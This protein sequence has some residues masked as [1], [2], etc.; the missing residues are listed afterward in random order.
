MAK[1]IIS[2][3]HAWATR[4]EY[5]CPS[6]ETTPSSATDLRRWSI[7]QTTTFRWALDEDA[8]QYQLAGFKSI[9]V[10]RKKLEEFGVERGIDLIQES[11]LNVSSLSWAGG[12]TGANG[13]GFDE[14]IDDAREAIQIASDINADALVVSPGTRAGHTRKHA[15]RLLFDALDVLVDDAAKADVVLALQPMHRH[16]SAQWTYL[17]SIDE[18]LSIL[19]YYSSPH[20]RLAIDLAHFWQEDAFE[21][22]FTQLANWLAVVQA[23]DHAGDICTP[24]N[25]CLP[26]DGVVPVQSILDAILAAGYRGSFELGLWSH[27]I[28]QADYQQVLE[29]CRDRCQNLATCSV[30]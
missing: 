1:E 15:R 3:P 10:W 9:G 13:Y 21:D 8:E 2:S 23:N 20:L 27:E 19:E 6:P 17:N 24:Y 25:H 12:F 7:N 18:T 26:G 30:S 22:R 11:G 4:A 16:F 14:A 5:S 29:S 28:W